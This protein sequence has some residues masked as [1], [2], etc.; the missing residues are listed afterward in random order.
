MGFKKEIL[1]KQ[2]QEDVGVG[3]DWAPT[4]FRTHKCLANLWQ[5]QTPA[6]VSVRSRTQRRLQDSQRSQ[7]GGVRAFVCATGAQIADL[8]GPAMDLLHLGLA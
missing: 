7:H 5:Q 6:D 3:L 1:A 4:H 2:G 8:R